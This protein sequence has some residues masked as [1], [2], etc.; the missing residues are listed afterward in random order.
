M[1]TVG[2]ANDSPEP[3]SATPYRR[4]SALTQIIFA[5]TAVQAFSIRELSDLLAGARAHNQAHGISGLLL[6]HEGVFLEVLEGAEEDVQSLYAK[7]E[8]DPRH[9]HCRL[10]LRSV[11][12]KREF[13]EWLMGFVDPQAAAHDLA[14]YVE[15]RNGLPALALDTHHAKKVLMRFRE[16]AWHHGAES[17]LR[18]HRA[19]SRARDS[20]VPIQTR[21]S[22][23]S[24]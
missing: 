14:G 9:T 3:A 1:H 11:I 7:I 21:G 22:R 17:E 23:P 2:S 15:Y 18:A 8:V 24:R 16:G 10:L 13:G 4:V 5:S 19:A 6:Y 12:V 20:A